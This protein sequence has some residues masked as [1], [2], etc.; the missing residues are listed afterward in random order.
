VVASPSRECQYGLGKN[1]ALQEQRDQQRADF[2]HCQRDQV[3]EAFF[4][5]DEVLA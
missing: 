2:G 5:C 4:R 3:R 1:R